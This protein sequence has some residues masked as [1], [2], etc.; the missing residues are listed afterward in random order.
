[1]QMARRIHHA[2]RNPLP[3]RHGASQ[4]T[5]TQTSA[6]KGT[7]TTDGSSQRARPAAPPEVKSPK[8][9]EGSRGLEPN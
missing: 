2:R 1:M 9:E 4:G 6:S 8:N 3:R 7:S 5:T